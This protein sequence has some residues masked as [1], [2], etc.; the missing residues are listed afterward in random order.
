[1]KKTTDLTAIIHDG[2]RAHTVIHHHAVGHKKGIILTDGDD[3][4]ARDRTSGRTDVIDELRR[5]QS[6]FFENNFHPWGN[7][8]AASRLHPF[9]PHRTKISRVPHRCTDR[10]RIRIPVADHIPRCRH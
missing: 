4:F 7:F 8:A 3:V 6:R 10:I 5:F 1:M 2:N 9:I